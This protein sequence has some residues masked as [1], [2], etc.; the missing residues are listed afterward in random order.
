MTAIVAAKQG[1]QCSV[2]E[3]LLALD[4]IKQDIDFSSSQQRSIDFS[5]RWI[6]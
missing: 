1:M 4:I 3:K 2:R 5:S 6:L